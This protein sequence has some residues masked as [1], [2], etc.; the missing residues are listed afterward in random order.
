MMLETTSGQSCIIPNIEGVSLID[1]VTC[2]LCRDLKARLGPRQQR[3][4]Q[5]NERIARVISLLP[6]R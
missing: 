1:G 3:G 6:P 4:L 2:L 5:G